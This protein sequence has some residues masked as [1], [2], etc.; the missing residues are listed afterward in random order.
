[1]KDTT[2]WAYFL[3]TLGALF[4]IILQLDRL[5]TF[6]K[7]LEGLWIILFFLLAAALYLAA[8]RKASDGYLAMVLFGLNLMN[9]LGLYFLTGWVTML[10][11]G[12]VV[13]LIGFVMGVET[14]KAGVPKTYPGE[15]LIYEEPEPPKRAAKATKSS[16]KRPS[17]QRKSRSRKT[18]KRKPS[19][20]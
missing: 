14:L 11:I 19:R 7:I 10:I 6:W 15:E 9:A 20:K 13:S 3:L 1:M 8:A 18:T 12:A 5:G 16:K 4:V 2:Y 17:S